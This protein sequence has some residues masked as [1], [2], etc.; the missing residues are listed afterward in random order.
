MEHR[1]LH[2]VELLYRPAALLRLRP[3]TRGN[4]AQQCDVVYAEAHGVGLVM[5][6]FRPCRESNG[7][8]IIDVVSGGWHSDRTLLNE[9]LGLGLID[10]CCERGFT[11]F[12]VSPGSMTLFPG[13]DMVR[14]VHAAI[15]HVKLHSREYG[16]A[17][18]R[19]G[20]LGVSAGGHLAAL[21]A[22]HPQRAHPASREPARRQGTELSA[23]AVF[24]PPT[25]L[26]DY[27]GSRFDRFPLA[28]LEVD[29]LLFRDGLPGKSEADI[30]ARLTEL[31]PARLTPLHLPP[32]LI[33]Q[34]K[35]DPIVPWRQAERLAAML[36]RHGGRVN[37]VYRE[38]GGHLW[39][40]IAQEVETAAA[41]LAQILVHA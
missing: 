6:V 24:F 9:H 37:T 31:S 39:S 34:G 21:A 38:D 3:H 11:L 26:L 35:K 32:F 7:L 33:I 18:D 27:G 25:D 16:V 28:A 10:A 8:G 4:Y 2:P 36:Q 15:R 30:V 5:D 14:H 23:A 19:L 17:P 1:T 41:W 12:A 13:P 20:I 22:L 29:R 40:G